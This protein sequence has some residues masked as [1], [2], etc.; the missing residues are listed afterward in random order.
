MPLCDKHRAMP[1][2][3]NALCQ[4]A[5]KV[6]GFEQASSSAPLMTSRCLP[7]QRT[8]CTDTHVLI[9]QLPLSLF[10]FF[11]FSFI[12][13]STWDYFIYFIFGV[14][15]N[16]Q[17]CI[18]SSSCPCSGTWVLWTNNHQGFKIKS[19][20]Q[21]QAWL[22]KLCCNSNTDCWTFHICFFFETVQVFESL[23]VTRE[24]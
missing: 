12:L 17:R 1:A 20:H 3:L 21:E 7:C 10:S 11:S 9:P 24:V 19:M 14:W 13:P 5:V 15:N 6:K 16:Y 22:K 23:G 8:V 4:P 18:I 2:A